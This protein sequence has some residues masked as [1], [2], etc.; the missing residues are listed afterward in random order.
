MKATIKFKTS[1]TLVGNLFPNASFAFEKRDTVVEVGFTVESFKNLAWLGGGGYDL[2][3][4]YVY[5]VCFRNSGGQ[6]IRGTYCPVVFENLADP[7]LSGREEL[8]YPKIF[9]DIEIDQRNGL[10]RA[11]VSWR[12]QE[13]ADFE[14][15]GLQ[16]QDLAHPSQ[17]NEQEPGLI[18][19]KYIPATDREQRGKADVEYTVF[20]PHD[21]KASKTVSTQI[22]KPADVAFKINDLG[23]V[24]LPTL[25]HV[26]SRIAELPV[27]EV[28]EGGVSTCQG[29]PNLSG[30]QRI[31]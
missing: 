25:H 2:L 30:A 31:S 10:Y 17:I 22:S 1:G 29:V 13:W 11:K 28:L 20:I 7:I 27:F 9:S 3:A 24:K 16:D 18:V 5:N 4:F 23:P 8:G 6:A 15:K 12:G 14:W 26:V 19:H 21:G